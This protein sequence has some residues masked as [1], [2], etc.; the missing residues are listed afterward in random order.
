MCV[1]GEESGGRLSPDRARPP[2]ETGGWNFGKS[3]FADCGAA[4][5]PA[6][7]TWPGRRRGMRTRFQVG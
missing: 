7:V 4:I 3:A 5:G 6:A 2:V 1:G